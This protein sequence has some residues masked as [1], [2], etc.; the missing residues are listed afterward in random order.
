MKCKI[1]FS[2]FICAANS[3]LCEAG[4]IAPSGK[5]YPSNIENK[6]DLTVQGEGSRQLHLTRGDSNWDFSVP[7]KT[8]LF[9]EAIIAYVG[10][11]DGYVSWNVKLRAPYHSTKNFKPYI[12]AIKSDVG[13]TNRDFYA[14][15]KEIGNVETISPISKYKFFY[16]LKYLVS[17]RRHLIATEKSKPTNTDF[18]MVYTYLLV[19][20][21]LRSNGYWPDQ[22][23]IETTDWLDAHHENYKSKPNSYLYKNSKDVS[24]LVLKIRSIEGTFAQELFDYIKDNELGQQ[25]CDMFASLYYYLNSLTDDRIKPF[26]KNAEQIKANALSGSTKC[27]QVTADTILKSS[28]NFDKN[29]I[30]DTSL[31]LEKKIEELEKLQASNKK[32]K[33]KEIVMRSKELRDV[34][35]ALQ[36]LF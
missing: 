36:R 12:Y 6:V 28:E 25:R 33:S 17:R 10:L 3:T 2:I 8:N 26:Q 14:L 29:R 23:L 11:P 27:D 15:E 30:M 21:E 31:K 18:R 5:Q 22:H 19:G 35:R 9:G 24:D 4:T 32:F 16:R 20:K 7:K 1:L 34:N 13:T